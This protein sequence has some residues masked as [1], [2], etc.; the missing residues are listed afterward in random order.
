MQRRFFTAALP[1]ALIVA[2]ATFATAAEMAKDK[3]TSHGESRAYL[4]G[5]NLPSTGI[6]LEGYCPV[7]YIEANKAIKGSPEF[8]S[9]Y[10]GVTYYFVSSDAKRLFD[11]NPEKYLPAYGGWCATG[12][13]HGKNFPVDPTSFKVVNGRT[14]L[15]LKNKGVDAKRLWDQGNE[16]QQIA[17]A[18]A[19]WEKH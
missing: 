14:L 4:H 1:V 6:A 13:L 8:P 19:N 12:I 2:G 11:S 7:A 10:N 16:R 17:K 9:T 3:M 18:D 5:Y 15:F